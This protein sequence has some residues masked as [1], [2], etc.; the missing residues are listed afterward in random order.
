MSCRPPYPEHTQHSPPDLL[1]KACPVMCYT[2]TDLG[3]THPLK[4]MWAYECKWTT[5]LK[6]IQQYSCIIPN[7]GLTELQLRKVEQ[8]KLVEVQI[9]KHTKTQNIPEWIQGSGFGIFTFHFTKR[10]AK[11]RPICQ[12]PKSIHKDIICAPIHSMDPT[13][14]FVEKLTSLT[15]STSHA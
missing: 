8:W 1:C 9:V 2:C 14:S 15:G 7:F 13:S 11:L 4:T 6:S 5:P 12:L 3:H 10:P